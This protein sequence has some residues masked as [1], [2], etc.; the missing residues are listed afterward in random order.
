MTTPRVNRAQAGGPTLG[1]VVREGS[2]EETSKLKAE[3]G[4]EFLA[5]GTTQTKHEELP[6][7]CPQ[8]AS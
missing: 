5:K 3:P 6:R 4:T 8:V 1:R 2:P 7:M